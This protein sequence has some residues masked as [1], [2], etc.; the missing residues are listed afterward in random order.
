MNLANFDPGKNSALPKVS[1]IIPNYN[2]KGFLKPCLDALRKQTVTAEEIIL[3]DNG[4]IDGSL[5]LVESMYPEVQIISLTGNKGFA[6]AVNQGVIRSKGSLVAV[7]NNDTVADSI[8]LEAAS[9]YLLEN[10]EVGFCASKIVKHDKPD[11]I[12]S[13]GHGI[14]RSGLT[15][16]K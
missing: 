7:L 2:G 13:V 6:E 9:S 11:V 4:S 14:K 1:V 8:W 16:A 10:P 15:T 5:E 3:V 12:D